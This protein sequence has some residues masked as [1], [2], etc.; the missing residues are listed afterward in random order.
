VSRVAAA[1]DLLWNIRF[2]FTR[3][4]GFFDLTGWVGVGG[5]VLFRADIE[6][7]IVSTVL[8]EV[9]ENADEGPGV[10]NAECSDGAETGGTDENGGVESEC[11]SGAGVG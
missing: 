1:E 9:S 4:R 2:K 7:A 11:R 6:E 3:R 10:S 5:A 8:E